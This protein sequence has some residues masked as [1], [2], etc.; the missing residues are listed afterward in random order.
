M[1]LGDNN[2]SPEC[3][4]VIFALPKEGGPLTVRGKYSEVILA[5][6]GIETQIV[7]GGKVC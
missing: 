7:V 5:W 2:G 1:I 6:A 3:K 4:Q